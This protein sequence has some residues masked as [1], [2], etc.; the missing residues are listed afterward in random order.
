MPERT[1]DLVT[2]LSIAEC[3][4]RFRL[5]IEQG[6][7]V[8]SQV[9]GVVAKLMGGNDLQYYTPEDTPFTAANDDPDDFVIGVAI[10]RL[11][12][13][14]THGTNV[15]MAVWDRGSHRDVLLWSHSAMFGVAHAAG[16]LRKLEELLVVGQPVTMP[17]PQ[18]PSQPEVGAPSPP[19]PLAPESPQAVSD[20]PTSSSPSAPMAEPPS[21]TAEMINQLRP[22]AVQPVTWDE[23]RSGLLEFATEA[24]NVTVDVDGAK[25]I[26]FTIAESEGTRTQN[27]TITYVEGFDGPALFRVESAFAKYS[28]EAA[29]AAVNYVLQPENSSVGV[30]RL[31]KDNL[32]LRWTAAI[33]TVPLSHVY[34]MVDSVASMAD[35]LEAKLSGQDVF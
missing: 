6:R 8:G 16:V 11:N 14:H 15:H 32:A 29:V 26:L 21:L 34:T 33:G 22:P 4:D 28:D 23:I 25:F 12:K 27:V 1:M 31:G 19:S 20:T 30:T 9:G 10:P 2:T 35:G 7:G 18:P 3:A 5:G 17:P 13:A 24:E